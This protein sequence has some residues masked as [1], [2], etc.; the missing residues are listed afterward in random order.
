M[1][2][3]ALK[4][5][6]T[7]QALIIDFSFD[8]HSFIAGRATI[9]RAGFCILAAMMLVLILVMLLLFTWVIVLEHCSRFQ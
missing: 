7:Y 3:V 2:A 1:H 6:V 9:V 4:L 5:S 8:S